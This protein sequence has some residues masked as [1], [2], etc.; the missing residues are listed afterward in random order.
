[1]YV[2]G[3]TE[4]THAAVK[5]MRSLCEARLSGDYDLE[6]INAVDRPDLA[7]ADG[8]LIAPTVVRLAPL[9]EQRAYGD[10]S[11][12]DRAV[13]LLGLPETDQAVGGD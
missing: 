6:V 5:N 4:R 7:E 9:P 2:A 1:M 12:Q 8:I 3:Q 13:A 10:L 11:D